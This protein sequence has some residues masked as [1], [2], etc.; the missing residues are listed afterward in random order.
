MKT[1]DLKLDYQPREIFHV[2]RE[3]A[4]VDD[5]DAILYESIAL[6]GLTPQAVFRLAEIHSSWNEFTWEE[7]KERLIIE[8]L[9]FERDWN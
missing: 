8:G 3:G 7:A 1:S 6:A 2:T 9:M 4:I 5:R